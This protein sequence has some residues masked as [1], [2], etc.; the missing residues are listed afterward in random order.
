MHRAKQEIFVVD[1]IDIY[2][3]GVGPAYGPRLRDYEPVAAILETRSAFDDHRL[4]NRECMLAAEIGA[5]TI[6]RDVS[7]LPVFTTL[8]LMF[9]PV[10]RPRRMLFLVGVPVLLLPVLH[11]LPVAV[12]LPIWLSLALAVTLFVLVRVF[13][14]LPVLFV[15]G[16]TIRFRASFFLWMLILLRV[17]GRGYSEE[18]G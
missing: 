10:F 1:V 15:G 8:C 7:T 13:L 9:V 16:L 6:I 11:G 12:S 5:K 2:R 17:H 3:V 18:Y 14:I 4:A